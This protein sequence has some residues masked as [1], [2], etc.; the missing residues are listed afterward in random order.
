MHHIKA[1]FARLYSPAKHRFPVLL[2]AVILIVYTGFV[3]LIAGRSAH[4]KTEKAV[5]AEYEEKLTALQRELQTEREK[6]AVKTSETTTVNAEL[7]IKAEKLAKVLYGF[8]NNDKSDLITACWCV[9]NRVD[10]KTGEYAYLTSLEDVIA[11]PEQW[12]GYSDENPVIEDLYQI[13]YAQLEIWLSGGHR[14]V[15][16]EYVFLVWSPGEIYLKT[17][18]TGKNDTRTWHYNG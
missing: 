14:P 6:T 7:V 13:A 2:A 17:S 11:Q 15:S 5:T 4:V 10:I 12:M 9:F 1:F 18:L 8:K 16:S 3:S